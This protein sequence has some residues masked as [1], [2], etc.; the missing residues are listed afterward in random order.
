[1]LAIIIPYYKLSF[2][3]ETIQSLASQ[4]D[5]RFK[6]YIGDDAS[7]EDCTFL[8][9]QFRGK[10]DFKYHR[11]ENNL[12][13]ISLSKQWDRCIALSAEEEWIMILGDDDVL[14]DTVVASW[15]ENYVF[16]NE[17]SNLIRFATK[18][19]NEKSETISKVY[20]HPLWEKESDFFIRSEKKQ[21]RSSLSEYIFSRK[22]YIKYGFYDYPLA[23]GSDCKAWLEFPD[24]KLIYTINDSIVHFRISNLNISGRKDSQELKDKANIQL[25]KDILTKK[26]NLFSHNQRLDLLMMYELAIKEN[27]KLGMQEW[28]FL[29][30]LYIYNFN[31]VSFCKCIRRFF[32][33]ILALDKNRIKIELIK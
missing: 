7:A 29:I 16:F 21:S 32:V 30:K 15:Y 3:A 5:K 9:E 20:N 2:F 28:S 1:M 8:L 19:I 6:V 33:S 26:L 27:R 17:K 13:G 4:T 25:F 22:S 10:F 23:W 14:E 18:V 12:G 11:F 31:F 24:A